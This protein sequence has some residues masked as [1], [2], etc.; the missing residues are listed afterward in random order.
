VSC[1]CALSAVEL[2]RLD[3][4]NMLFAQA[5]AGAASGSVEAEVMLRMISS[6]ASKC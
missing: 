2:L 3:M 6:G 4:K 1:D 5:C